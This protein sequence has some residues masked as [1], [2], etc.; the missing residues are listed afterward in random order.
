MIWHG[1]NESFRTTIFL[2]PPPCIGWF[3]PTFS[4]FLAAVDYPINWRVENYKPITVAVN[5]TV[6]FKWIGEHG[7]AKIASEQCPTTFDNNPDVTV[8]APS[9]RGGTYVWT[10]KDKGVF[11]LACNEGNHCSR[12]QKIEITV[13]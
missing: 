2:F 12:G 3:S 13:A 8:L 7:V 10:A 1:Q 5:D 11:W 6:T 4:F 9:V